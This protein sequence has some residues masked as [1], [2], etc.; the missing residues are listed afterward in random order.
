[1]SETASRAELAGT[2]NA[3]YDA[4]AGTLLPRFRTGV[5]AERQARYHAACDIDSRTFGDCADVTILAQD[6]SLATTRAKLPNDGRIHTRHAIRQTGVIRV[7]ESLIINGRVARHTQT[8]RGVLVTC[9]FA[10]LRPDLSVPLEME[11]DYLLPYAKPAE[12]QPESGRTKS[13][14]EM[15]ADAVP[16]ATLALTPDKV[17][18]Y[19]AEV[20]NRIHFEPDFA[21]AQGYRAPLTQGLQQFT[22]LHG[23]FVA[24]HG[25]AERVNLEVRFRRPVFWDE[26]LSILRD[27]EGTRFISINDQGRITADMSAG[28]G[29]D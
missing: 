26:T 5:D 27:S 4:P 19:S 12:T 3:Y 8:P 11:T 15:P 29:N 20:G 22:A 2:L 21:A 1:M 23:A 14:D 10:F 25:P 6:N 17:K 28:T 13:R 9:L 7:G 16:A 18:A 24:M